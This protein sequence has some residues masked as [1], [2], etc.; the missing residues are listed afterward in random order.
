M[1]FNTLWDYEYLM[2]SNNMFVG[3]N[4]PNALKSKDVK[5]CLPPYSKRKSFLVDEYPAC[6]KN[7]MRSEGRTVSYFVPVQEGKG[8]WLDFNANSAHSHEVAIVVSVQGINP[9]TGLPCEGAQLEQYIDNCP[10]CNEPF[11]PDRLCEKCKIKY[12]KQNYI[13]TTTTPNGQ[14]W[15]DG[16]RS[17]E[18]VVRQYILTE[19]KIRGVASNLIG[20]DRVFAIGISFF[21]SKEKKKKDLYTYPNNDSYKHFKTKKK[22]IRY[23]NFNIT[24][25]TP[26]YDSSSSSAS[27]SYDIYAAHTDC[28]NLCKDFPYDNK[29]VSNTNIYSVQTKG[30][31]VGAGA[32]INQSVHDDIELLD[33]WRDDPEA[34]ICINYAL[35]GDVE[36][37]VSQGRVELENHQEGFLQGI[38]VG[39]K[40][41]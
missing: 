6:P 3:L 20:K 16:F 39:N 37:I 17:I 21:L 5:H 23:K 40:G 15:L 30:L 13:S 26:T 28:L 41:E 33:F 19:E 7:W 2:K 31:E 38:P 27:D 1:K 4:T 11:K 32:Q 14:L 25:S 24:N 9:I 29:N 8:M 22:R 35:E 12:P 34:I 36:K 10:K 18:G